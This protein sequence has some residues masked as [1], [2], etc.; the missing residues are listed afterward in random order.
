LWNRLPLGGADKYTLF[1]NT[2]RLPEI[3]HLLPIL[4]K[5]PCGCFS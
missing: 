4:R 2:R 3:P 1:R 5:K